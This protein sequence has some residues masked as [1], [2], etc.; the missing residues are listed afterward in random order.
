[1]KIVFLGDVFGKTGRRAV[2]RELPYLRQHYKA[3]VIIVNGENAAHGMGITT[4]IAQEFFALGINAKSFLIWK[5]KIAFCV[6]L[7]SQKGHQA[8]A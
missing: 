4:N 5:K 1:M 6:Q 8:R 2:S 7:T 3:D